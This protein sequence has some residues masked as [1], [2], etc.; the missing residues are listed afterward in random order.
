MILILN[1]HQ[2][3]MNKY[4]SPRH[5]NGPTKLKDSPMHNE[6]RN[7]REDLDPASR[8]KLFGG[9]VPSHED[10]LKSSSKI[11][12]PYE[13]S[14]GFNHSNISQ[15]DSNIYSKPSRKYEP[16]RHSYP[17]NAFIRKTNDLKSFIMAETERLVNRPNNLYLDANTRI[18]V[19]LMGRAPQCSVRKRMFK[20]GLI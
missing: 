17:T 19:E 13:S 20:L 2:N 9:V 10:Y 15:D 3:R 1:V 14:F 11:S 16:T 7:R 12:Y 8:A 6:F 5:L 4:T 18:E